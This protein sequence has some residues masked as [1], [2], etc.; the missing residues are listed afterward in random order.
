[1]AKQVVR[2][3]RVVCQLSSLFP[4]AGGR[5]A[6]TVLKQA[7]SHTPQL[8]NRPVWRQCVPACSP[9]HLLTPGLQETM[10]RGAVPPHLSID[11]AMYPVTRRLA[12]RRDTCARPP[13][14][15]ATQCQPTIPGSRLPCV[16]TTP[17]VHHPSLCLPTPDSQTAMAGQ[18]SRTRTFH[19]STSPTRP[20][21]ILLIPQK[22]ALRPSALP[23]LR[24][25]AAPP[26]PPHS[27]LDAKARAR[28]RS[29][30]L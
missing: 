10:F 15:T 16:P 3:Q 11:W 13:C 9:R 4:A 21:S 23:A 28:R 26:P 27:Y 7:E 1:M 6:L 22:T 29:A 5:V 24:P 8:V 19:Q 25:F 14:A 20:L 18:P 2:L 17:R 12:T 30:M